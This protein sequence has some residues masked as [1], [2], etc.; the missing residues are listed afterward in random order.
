MKKIKKILKIVIKSPVI[1]V[2]G[3]FIIILYVARYLPVI[4]DMFTKNKTKQKDSDIEIKE[5]N[6]Q[7]DLIKA[8]VID[9]AIK[10]AKDALNDMIGKKS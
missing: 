9:N 3:F 2:I 6:K 1:A 5:T 8:E 4:S 7:A 10:K